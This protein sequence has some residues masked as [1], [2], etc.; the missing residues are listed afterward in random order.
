MAS[1]N[2][3]VPG[4]GPDATLN[5]TDPATWVMALSIIAAVVAAVW[6]GHNLAPLVQAVAPLAAS[7]V[8]GAVLYSKHHLAAAGVAAMAANVA[9]E[10]T[11]VVVTTEKTVTT[12]TPSVAAPGP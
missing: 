7:I 2:S 10:V 1:T 5:V 8:T 3:P 9:G 11:D 4:T 12:H 6:P